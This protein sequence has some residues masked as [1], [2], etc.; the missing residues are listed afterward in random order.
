MSSPA[1]LKAV[2][3]IGGRSRR[4]GRAKH[5]LGIDERQSALTWLEH[6]VRILRPLV[7]EVVIAGEGELPAGCAEFPRI[8]DLPA[9]DGPLAGVLAAMR[10]D[11]AVDWL[12]VACDMPKVDAAAIAWLLECRTDGCLGV[13]PRLQEGTL[14]EP[15]FALYCRGAAALFERQYTRGEARISAVAGDSRILNPIVPSQLRHAW[16]NINT[17]EE[18]RLFYRQR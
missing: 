6:A 17:P 14:Y 11:P 18:L 7:A 13:V 15:L 5:L 16:R 9:I 3:L 12:V 4:M 8:A 10:S 1:P 2:L